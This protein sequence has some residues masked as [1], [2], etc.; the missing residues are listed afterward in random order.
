[1]I[2]RKIGNTPL[3]SGPLGIGCNKLL[4]PTDPDLVTTANT[5]I[6]IGINQFDGADVY[7]DGKCEHFFSKVLKPRRSAVTLV[8]KFGMIRQ[9]DGGVVVDGSPAYARRAC[10]AS[11]KRLDMECIDLYYLHRIDPK[12]PIE[13]S[14]GGMAELIK[15]GKV[16][17]IGICNTDAE[18]IRRA[19]ATHPLAAVQ[20]E[21]SLMERSVEKE[22]LPACKALGITFVAYGP[23]TYAFLSG[24]VKTHAD[25]PSDDQFRRRQSRFTEDNIARNLGLLAALDEVRAEA[26]GTRAQIALAWCLHR[27]WDVLPIPGSRKVHHLRD[28]AAAVDIKLSPAHVARLDAAFA[29]GAAHGNAGAG[30]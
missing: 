10:E 1:M 20:M 7:G 17:Q 2:S 27:P 19:H 23:L 28:N 8:S 9:P 15:A 18:T 5:A 30:R 3:T 14:I 12:I 11:L 26:G 4:D 16:R 24:E 21:Y 13:E 29:P 22:V 25:L 6:D